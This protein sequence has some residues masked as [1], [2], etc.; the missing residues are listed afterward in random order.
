[1]REWTYTNPYTT[2]RWNPIPTM[3]SIDIYPVPIVVCYVSKRFIGDPAVITIP[4]CPSAYGERTPTRGD[5]K[6]SPEILI[7][8][9]VVDPLPD[10]IFF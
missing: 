10:T 6:R 9:F 1:M 7:A 3:R 2:Y 5:I 8:P 4:L